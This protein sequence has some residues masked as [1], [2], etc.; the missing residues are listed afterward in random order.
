MEYWIDGV[1]SSLLRYSI[2]PVKKVCS[3]KIRNRQITLTSLFIALCVIVPFLFHLVGLG[4]IFLPMFLPILLAGFL[5]EFRFA[6]LVGLLGPVTSSLATGMPPFFPTAISMT[7][8]GMVAAS[9]ASFLFYTHKKS[10][11]LALPVAI[12][13]E[14]ITRVIMILLIFP[15][16]GLPAKQWSIIEITA[17]LPGIVLQ[18]FLIPLVLFMLWKSKIIERKLWWKIS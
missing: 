18:L 17:T 14:R 15:I 1:E 6:L 5:I 13:A 16:F 4:M 10:L 9:V 2:H 8:E 11:W 3:M 12:V 7:A